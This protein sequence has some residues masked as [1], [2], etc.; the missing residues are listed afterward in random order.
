M[1]GN[2]S[3][4]A[5]RSAAGGWPEWMI[6]EGA[7]WRPF[8]D[9][10]VLVKPE[11]TPR[12]AA[13]IFAACEK[14]L[15]DHLKAVCTWPRK[16]RNQNWRVG[17][18]SFYVLSFPLSPKVERFAQFWSE[19]HEEAVMLE[20]SS[21]ATPQSPPAVKLNEAQQDAIRDRGFEVGGGADNFGKSVTLANARAIR[22]LARET[23]SVL[24]E[25]LGYDGTVPLEYSLNL[26][27]RAKVGHVYDSLSL[28]VLGALLVEWGLPAKLEATQSGS[29]FL[30][31]RVGPV[32]LML[33]F[34][35]GT[36]ELPG[37]FSCLVVRTYPAVPKGQATRWA[38]ELN[39]RMFGF[40]ASVDGDGDLV[41]ESEIFLHGGV[42]AEHVKQRL[43]LFASM[44]EGL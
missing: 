11:G 21:G 17:D 14:T 1:A 4:P 8:E 2:S 39:Q 10:G 44:A 5:P 25:G 20:V 22:A 15:V 23:I 27:T 42:T 35:T 32:P 9:S 29:P 12:K 36:E 33:F 7:I 26:E 34:V 37:E 24:C 16:Q 40:R 13:A 28:E 38:A 43:Q 19:P 18:Y 3:S 30:T 6:R 41:L 31:T